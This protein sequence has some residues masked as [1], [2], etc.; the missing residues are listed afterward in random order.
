[1]ALGELMVI[2][3]VMVLGELMVIIRGHNTGRINGK[4]SGAL[5]WET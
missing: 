4:D 3:V 5:Y 2:I 1:M